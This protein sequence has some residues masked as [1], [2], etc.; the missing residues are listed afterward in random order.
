MYNYTE[1][2]RILCIYIYIYIY[3]RIVLVLYFI[4]LRTVTVLL[5]TFDNFAYAIL[6]IPTYIMRMKPISR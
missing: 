3:I 1:S 2:T 5:L 6:I 4:Y